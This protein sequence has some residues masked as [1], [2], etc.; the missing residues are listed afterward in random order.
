MNKKRLEHLIETLENVKKRDKKDDHKHFD[1]SVWR[2]DDPEKEVDCGTTACAL[3]WEATTPY[4]R[5]RGLKLIGNNMDGV[6]P[7]FKRRGSTVEYSGF[8]AAAVYFDISHDMAEALFDPDSYGD[9]Y[10]DI[11]PKHV[12]KRVKYFLKGGKVND[13]EPSYSRY[14]RYQGLPGGLEA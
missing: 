1:M 4:A 3:G 12:I 13:D 2:G 5:S 9:R 14:D 7:S 6:Y 10:E 11:T 8:D